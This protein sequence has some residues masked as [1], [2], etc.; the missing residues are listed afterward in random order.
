MKSFQ[1]LNAQPILDKLATMDLPLAI[2][3]KLLDPFKKASEIHQTIVNKRQVLFDK[4]GDKNKETGEM[5]INPENKDKFTAEYTK[6][7]ETELEWDFP[8]INVADFGDDVSLSI[9]DVSQIDWFLKA[10]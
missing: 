2:S 8:A 1:V 6:L 3:V 7:M 9:A 4:Y 10:A 5:S